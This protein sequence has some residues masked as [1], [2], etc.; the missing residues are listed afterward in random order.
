MHEVKMLIL[1]R[2]LLVAERAWFLPMF[3]T[4]IFLTF[5][6]DAALLLCH[7]REFRSIQQLQVKTSDANV[8]FST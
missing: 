8:F 5:A 3:Y 1:T 2:A 4:F 6:L 7:S